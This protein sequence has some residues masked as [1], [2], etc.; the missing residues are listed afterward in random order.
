MVTCVVST[1][2]EKLCQKGDK[3]LRKTGFKRDRH[4]PSTFLETFLV[5]ST[6]TLTT[7]LVNVRYKSET[8]G[9]EI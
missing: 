1:C 7:I 3:S 9:S 8:N 4:D 5:Y 6:Q 2:I